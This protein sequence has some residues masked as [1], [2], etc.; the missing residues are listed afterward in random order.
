ME[1]SKQYYTLEEDTEA[2]L[3][4]WKDDWEQESVNREEMDKDMLVS[5]YLGIKR[6]NK[7][8]E[9]KLEFLQNQ[10]QEK[11]GKGFV[12]YGFSNGEISMDS[13]TAQK[14]KNFEREIKQI[15]IKTQSYIRT[16]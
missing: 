5:E 2:V 7:I 8:L 11:V 14:V 6:R 1:D 10:Q 13:Q 9:E 16:T 3:E 4:H 15:K 12:N